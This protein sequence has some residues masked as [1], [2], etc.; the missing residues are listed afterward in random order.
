MTHPPRT[1][2]VIFDGTLSS[3]APGAKT[4]AGILY[5]LLRKQADSDVRLHYAPGIQ[6]RG[7]RK[8]RNVAAGTGTNRRIKRAYRW[9]AR[10]WRPG[11]RVFLFGYSRGA[12]GVRSLAGVIDLH[13]LMR[14]EAADR[15]NVERLYHYYCE[16]RDPVSAARFSKRYCWPR[17]AVK[18]EMIGVWDTVKAL[19]LRAPVVWSWLPNETEFHSDD[20]SE[21]VGAGYHAL[22]H[23]ERRVAFSPV[24]WRCPPGFKGHVEQ[25]WF[26]G[27]HADVGGQVARRP[28]ARGLA[29]IALGWMLGK[30]EGHGLGLPDGWAE[31]YPPDPLAPS[32]GMDHGFGWLFRHRRRRKVGEDASES[33]HPSV[34]K[35]AAHRRPRF[36]RFR[37]RSNA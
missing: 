18:I 12:Y 27:A 23:D 30:A 6:W 17:G 32:V 36:A 26:P 11:D 34:T 10:N 22:A 3:L 15:G 7:W 19:G 5:K 13:G 25:L 33:L 37:R 31:E 21:I 9:L 14:A 35:R 8:L 16:G 20:L 28:A 2:V 24:L 4:N 29:N 1:L